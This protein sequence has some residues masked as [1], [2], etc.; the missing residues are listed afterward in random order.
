MRKNPSS[1]KSAKRYAGSKYQTPN[2][3][4]N[5]NQH[6]KT[7]AADASSLAWQQLLELKSLVETFDYSIFSNLSHL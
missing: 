4:F 2:G 5:D 7:G 1:P 6:R 3:R